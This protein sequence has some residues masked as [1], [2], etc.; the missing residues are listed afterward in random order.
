MKESDDGTGRRATGKPAPENPKDGKAEKDM[1]G[2]VY[3]GGGVPEAEVPKDEAHPGETHPLDGLE[4]EPKGETADEL[5]GEKGEDLINGEKPNPEENKDENILTFTEK[6]GGR[7]KLIVL[8]IVIVIIIIAVIYLV[9]N[10]PKLGGSATTTLH[11]T[12]IVGGKTTVTTTIPHNHNA[13]FLANLDLLHNYTGPATLNKTSC[14]KSMQSTVDGLNVRYNQS[15]QFYIHDTE[16]SGYCPLTITSI[17][18]TTPG[19]R[20]VSVNPLLP[21]KIP[22]Y[23]SVY[24]IVKLQAPTFNYTGPLSITINE[25]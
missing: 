9:L 16:A 11:T 3:Q 14:G 13:S 21:I 12:T 20:I 2:L 10:P 17:K 4:G 24:I 23:S 19:F 1:K 7:G 18:V 15:T 5:K 6:E 25:N 8:A 22:H